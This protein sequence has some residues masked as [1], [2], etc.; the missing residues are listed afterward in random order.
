MHCIQGH[1]VQKINCLKVS[2]FGT[3][4]IDEAKPLLVQK[5]SHWRAWIQGGI[6]SSLDLASLGRNWC[7]CFRRMLL[8][9]AVTSEEQRMSQGH[10]MDSG[11]G[12]GSRIAWEVKILPFANLP[13][14]CRAG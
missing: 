2:C 9:W 10:K 3:Q 11:L 6:L 14:F 7:R 12:Y 8:L 5:G 4:E 1:P 13:E